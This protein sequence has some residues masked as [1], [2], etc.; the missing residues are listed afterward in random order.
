LGKATLERKLLRELDLR[1][2]PAGFHRVNRGRFYGDPYSREVSGVR[3]TLGIGIRP[4]LEALEAEVV[5]ATVRFNAVEDLVARFEDPHPLIGPEDV[6]ARSTLGAEISPSQPQRGD[7]LY[8]WGGTDRKIWLIHTPNEV[9]DI[10]FQ[11]AAYALEKS[12]PIFAALSNT[13]YALTLLSGDDARSRCYSGLASA[14]AKAAIAF[15]YL[16]L[17]EAPAMQLAETKVARLRGEARSE[18]ARWMDR[19]FGDEEKSGA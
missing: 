11:I 12:E 4:Y 7:P 2:A 5:N 14:R 13:E 8:G 17:G 9:P 19:F 15:A 16:S 10:A 3:H 1:L 18:V 6:A